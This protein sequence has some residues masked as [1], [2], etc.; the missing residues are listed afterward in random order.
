MYVARMAMILQDATQ[1]SEDG[2]NVEATLIAGTDGLFD[3]D[4][5]FLDEK[6]SVLSVD[7]RA[8]FP[9]AVQDRGE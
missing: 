6:T 5:Y 4:L 9:R 8:T 7:L 2:A 1:C 3:R